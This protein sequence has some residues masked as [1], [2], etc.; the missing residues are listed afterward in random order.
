MWNP[1]KTQ[2]LKPNYRIVKKIEELVRH[3]YNITIKMQNGDLFKTELFDDIID[4]YYV[5]SLYTGTRDCSIFETYL[6]TRLIQEPRI[7]SKMVWK[8]NYQGTTM[9]LNS[10][11]ISWVQY[12]KIPFETVQ[13]ENDVLELIEEEQNV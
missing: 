2:Q 3:K 5:R 13:V 12:T 4:Q 7:D 10:D 11:Q 6:Y 1:F 9:T 8:F